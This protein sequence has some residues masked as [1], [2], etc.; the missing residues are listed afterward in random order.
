MDK[1]TIFDLLVVVQSC[2]SLLIS[3][4]KTPTDE[5]R[6]CFVGVLSPCFI[7]DGKNFLLSADD[8]ECGRQSTG[9]ISSPIPTSLAFANADTESGRFSEQMSKLSDDVPITTWEVLEVM[10]GTAVTFSRR[11]DKVLLIDRKQESSKCLEQTRRPPTGLWLGIPQNVFQ[12]WHCWLVSC[13]KTCR[14]YPPDD[15]SC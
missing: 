7:G 15:D 13:G 4:N 12:S 1:N 9:F 14:E 2:G 11:C 10:V 8:A 3:W 5:L 6:R